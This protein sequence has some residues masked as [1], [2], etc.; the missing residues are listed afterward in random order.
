MADE[1]HLVIVKSGLSGL[2]VE[3]NDL[4]EL[5]TCERAIDFGNH[6]ARIIATKE[7]AVT[8]A[9]RFLERHVKEVRDA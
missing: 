8:I 7:I 1:L 5:S 6:E 4:Y 9:E 3:A 2:G